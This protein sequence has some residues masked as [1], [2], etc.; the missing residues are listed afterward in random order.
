MSILVIKSQH[1]SITLTYIAKRQIKVQKWTSIKDYFI[2]FCYHPKQAQEKC[3][4]WKK[5]RLG[6][7]D[8]SV[9]SLEFCESSLPAEDKKGKKTLE[10]V[11][12][13]AEL[14][15][16]PHHPDLFTYLTGKIPKSVGQKPV[17]L[18]TRRM[19]WNVEWHEMSNVIHHEISNV[20]KC[21]MSW[22]AKCREMWWWWW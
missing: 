11:H 3:V 16:D 15:H 5:L 19:T 6:A 13:Y 22:N 21:Q 2:W 17:R 14:K 7:D 1:Y 10:E 20:I 4:H 9:A 18:P 8:T 12:T